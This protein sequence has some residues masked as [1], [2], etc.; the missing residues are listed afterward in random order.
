MPKPLGRVSLEPGSFEIKI[1]ANR[2]QGGELFRLRNIELK[3]F[4]SAN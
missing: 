2:I 1:T 4:A 3:P